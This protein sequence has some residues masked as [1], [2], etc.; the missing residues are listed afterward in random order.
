MRKTPPKRGKNK[1]RK[2]ERHIYAK[3]IWRTE[4]TEMNGKDFIKA[5]ADEPVYVNDVADDPKM[6]TLYRENGWAFT[7]V[8]W[9]GERKDH[10]NVTIHYVNGEFDSVCC[11][12]EDDYKD[13]NSGVSLFNL[14]QVIDMR[15][16]LT[17]AI[18]VMK[19]K[20]IQ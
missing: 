2:C 5:E 4:A 9:M 8:E 19:K 17:R 15:D 16:Q 11:Y 3:G 12:S 7:R 10:I 14:D 13:E 1:K 20:G 6:A 18:N